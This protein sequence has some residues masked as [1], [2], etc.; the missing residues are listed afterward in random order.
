MKSTTT[1]KKLHLN[2]RTIIHLNVETMNLVRTGLKNNRFNTMGQVAEKADSS[3]PCIIET[4]VKTKD[5]TLCFPT[6]GTD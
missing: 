1:E 2:K 4:H 6:T 3:I 5:H